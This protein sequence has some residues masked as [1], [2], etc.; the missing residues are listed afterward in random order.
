MI[1]A[2]IAFWLVCV[3]PLLAIFIYLVKKDKIKGK[4]G[5]VILTVLVLF[6][7]FAIVYMT[8][9]FTAKPY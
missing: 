6:G 2:S 1:G 9:D 5:F 8:T 3:L 4:W 7:I